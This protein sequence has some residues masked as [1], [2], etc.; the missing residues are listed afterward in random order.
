MLCRIPALYSE[1]VI[2]CVATSA[3]IGYSVNEIPCNVR[4]VSKILCANYR[5]L[6]IFQVLSGVA[7]RPSGASVP[8][9]PRSV[10]GIQTYRVE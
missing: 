5:G 4:M 10:S 1:K 3:T 7:D 8:E 9:A 6:P 2:V